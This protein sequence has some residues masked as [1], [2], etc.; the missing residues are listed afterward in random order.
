MVQWQPGTDAE[1]AMAAARD[2][3][4]RREYF[5]LLATSPLYLP[6]AEIP[7]EDSD[8]PQRFG[9]WEM[10]GRTFLVVYTS[11]ECLIAAVG[12]AAQGYT[13]TD[14]AELA[15]KWPDSSWWLAVN[16]GLQLD[17]YVPIE[18]VRAAADGTLTV[19]TAE[20]AVES[21]VSDPDL[22]SD[23]EALQQAE[24]V[25]REQRSVRPDEPSGDQGASPS[26]GQAPTPAAPAQVDEEPVTPEN[27]TEEAMLAARRAGD[28]E[29]YLEALLAADVVVPVA[30][31]V[32]D[33]DQLAEP[34]FPWRPAT[35]M[36]SPTIE[37]FTARS[38]F[39]AK[40]D[41]ETPTLTAPFM[42]VLVAWPDPSYELAVD[43]GDGLELRLSGA[44]L[45]EFIE[46]VESALADE[47]GDLGTVDGEL[48]RGDGA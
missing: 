16:P 48:A 14:Y 9:L 39:T 15:A 26:A 4:D 29:A 17:C 11:P 13:V 20:E 27:E 33:V 38:R 10:A 1:L 47:V 5:R 19:P 37:L 41:P 40:Y 34:G 31:P 30:W 18:S 46:S 2:A 45:E 32:L 6:L 25:L 44:A 36:E 42:L 12:P 23:L 7:A 21:A 24:A 43:P 8:E 22:A 35:G 3:D 28:M